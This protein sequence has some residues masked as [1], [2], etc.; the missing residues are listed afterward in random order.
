VQN[1]TWF[2]GLEFTPT[3]IHQQDVVTGSGP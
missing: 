3:P 1:V 2:Y